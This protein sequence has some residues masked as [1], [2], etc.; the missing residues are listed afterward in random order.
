[1]WSNGTFYGI[2]NGI[3]IQITI[4]TWN[5]HYNHGIK[6]WNNANEN[7]SKFN[8]PINN[9]NKINLNDEDEKDG[10]ADADAEEAEWW[11]M[12]DDFN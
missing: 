10:D 11:N 8:S 3:T 1:M 2:N 4:I 5:I 6:W 9:D 12:F 7:Y